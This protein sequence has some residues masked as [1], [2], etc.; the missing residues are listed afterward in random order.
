MFVLAMQDGA[1]ENGGPPPLAPTTRTQKPRPLLLVA[2]YARFASMASQIFAA[3]S[4]PPSR[5]MA[6]MP[7]GDVTLISVR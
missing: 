1:F 3:I 4:G 5:A 2:P 7:V 6:R